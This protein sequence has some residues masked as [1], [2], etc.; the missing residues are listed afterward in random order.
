MQRPELIIKTH[1][2]PATPEGDLNY[3]NGSPGQAFAEWIR[4]RLINAG[5]TC[6]SVFQE[7]YGWGFWATSEKASLWISVAC[8]DSIQPA[9]WHITVTH[10]GGLNLKQWLNRKAGQ[11]IEAQVF[12]LIL[13]TVESIPQEDLTVVKLEQDKP[14]SKD[15]KLVAIALLIQFLLFIGMVSI[16]DITD[17]W[18]IIG[19]LWSYQLILAYCSLQPVVPIHPLRLLIFFIFP[20]YCWFYVVKSRFNSRIFAI[21]IAFW[22]LLAFSGFSEYH[23]LFWPGVLPLYLIPPLAIIAKL[24]NKAWAL[25]Y[26]ML[27]TFCLWGGWGD[28]RKIGATLFILPCIAALHGLLWLGGRYVSKRRR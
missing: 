9:T 5:I 13:Q 16:E 4:V 15:S 24:R 1:Q 2:F 26:Y 3:N 21:A 28:E 23:S 22:T 19:W 27:L 10:S 17:H 11:V 18:S 6:Q 20:P 14:I 12:Q 7:D 8:S 25:F